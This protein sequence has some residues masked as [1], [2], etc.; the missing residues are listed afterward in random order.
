TGVGEIRAVDESHVRMRLRSDDQHKYRWVVSTSV[1]A[2]GAAYLWRSG[3]FPK[4]G[5]PKR[6][7]DRSLRIVGAVLLSA[8]VIYLL[9]LGSDSS[10]QIE[11]SPISRIL[12]SQ[13][14]RVSVILW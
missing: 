14:L 5:E 11:D 8:V 9:G 2:C 13:F 4:K 1:L 10:D 3:L 12:G 6:R 7:L